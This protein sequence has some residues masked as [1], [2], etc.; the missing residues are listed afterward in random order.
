MSSN[1]TLEEQLKEFR[2]QYYQE[3]KKQQFLKTHRNLLVLQ[4]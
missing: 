2:N 4:K 3:K 1:A